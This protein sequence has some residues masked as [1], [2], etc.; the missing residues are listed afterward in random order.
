M[1]EK[2]FSS[3]LNGAVSL[4]KRDVENKSL[5]FSVL[6][7]FLFYLDIFEFILS[8]QLTHFSHFSF[9]VSLACY[10]FDCSFVSSVFFSLVSF[11]F[12]EDHFYLNETLWFLNFFVFS[13]FCFRCCCC[14]FFSSFAWIKFLLVWQELCYF[15]ES[16]WFFRRISLRWLW[17]NNMK[18]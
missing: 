14:C 4:S 8:F 7:Y 18:L 5:S 13:I 3:L 17:S 12:D 10:F 15:N 11:C 6:F 2:P 16:L 9:L 1:E